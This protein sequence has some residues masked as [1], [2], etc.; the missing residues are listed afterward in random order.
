MQPRPIA[1]TNSS[2]VP[3]LL[4]S[5]SF[6]LIFRLC[7]SG[8]GPGQLIIECRVINVAARIAAVKRFRVGRVERRICAKAFGQIRVGDKELTE[9]DEVSI[10]SFEYSFGLLPIVACGR[11]DFNLEDRAQVLCR[12]SLH[13][14]DGD[15]AFR[16][17]DM[18]ISQSE[19]VQLTRDI[20]KGA[21]RV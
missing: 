16:L 8:R 21:R 12:R 14:I 4:C 10:A 20:T 1:D 3:N 9:G 11:D 7:G 13:A 15:S 6:P 19:A 2:L 17:D 5:I 18:Q